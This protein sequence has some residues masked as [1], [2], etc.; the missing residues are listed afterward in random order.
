MMSLLF[1]FKCC[2]VS[3]IMFTN[4]HN[5]PSQICFF[6]FL[7]TAVPISNRDPRWVGAWWLGFLFFGALAII[8]AFPLCCFPRRLSE[9]KPK[10]E[11][12]EKKRQPKIKESA[13]GL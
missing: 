7:L 10:E 5:T 6:I 9:K 11:K 12:P 8:A 1:F 3:K 4:A 13:K 2:Y